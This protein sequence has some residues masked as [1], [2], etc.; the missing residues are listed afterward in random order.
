MN[1]LRLAL[2]N[3]V[4]HKVFNGFVGGLTHHI[5]KPRFLKLITHKS[6]FANF[7]KTFLAALETF[8]IYLSSL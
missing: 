2:S 4:I 5:M 7:L 3:G 1:R 6:E 8:I